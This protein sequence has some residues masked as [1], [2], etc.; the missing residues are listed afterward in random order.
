MARVACEQC[1][2]ERRAPAEIGLCDHC[3]RRNALDVRQLYAAVCMLAWLD[4]E[5]LAR[6]QVTYP[7]RVP[8]TGLEAAALARAARALQAA[9]LALPAAPF[10]REAPRKGPKRATRA[11]E[12]EDEENA[13]VPVPGRRRVRRR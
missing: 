6:A 3:R 7:H 1:G 13:A 11:G 8:L 10:L 4:L 9:A 2:G 5:H 12:V